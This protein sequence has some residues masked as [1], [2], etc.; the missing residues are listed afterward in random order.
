MKSM[1]QL[2]IRKELDEY[3][4]RRN[5]NDNKPVKAK[6]I[7]KRKQFQERHATIK[8]QDINAFGSPNGNGVVVIRT[9]EPNFFSM[10]HDR[11]MNSFRKKNKKDQNAR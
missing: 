3:L 7:F 5:N 2:R 4:S 1:R 9:E 11:I 10:L 8:E 6:D